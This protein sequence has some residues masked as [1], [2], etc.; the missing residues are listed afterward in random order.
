MPRCKLLSQ[1]HGCQ[2]FELEGENNSIDNY[3]CC[4]TNQIDTSMKYLV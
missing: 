1:P 4:S 2:D 3:V